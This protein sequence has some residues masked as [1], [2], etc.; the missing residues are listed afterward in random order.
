VIKLDSEFPIPLAPNWNATFSQRSVILVRT[1]SRAYRF[2]DIGRRS[3]W[4]GQGTGI[5]QNDF[6]PAFL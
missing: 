1:V 6:V 4:M 2:A 3:Q 5:D